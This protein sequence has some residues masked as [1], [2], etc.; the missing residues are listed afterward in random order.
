M[1]VNTSSFDVSYVSEM[2]LSFLEAILVK[3][4]HVLV[5]SIALVGNSL[6]ILGSIKYH[7]IDMDKVSLILMGELKNLLAILSYSLLELVTVMDLKLFDW[8]N[9]SIL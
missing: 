8:W 1:F 4:Y 9:F 7:A 5:L 3:I 2:H 6:V